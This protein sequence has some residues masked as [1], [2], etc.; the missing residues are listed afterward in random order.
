V[1]IEVDMELNQPEA[2]GVLGHADEAQVLGLACRVDLT[3][4]R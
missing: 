3:L 1:R 2:D 4:G